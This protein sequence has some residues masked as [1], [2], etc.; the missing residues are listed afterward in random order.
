MNWLNKEIAERWREEGRRYAS[1]INKYVR[2]GTETGWPEGLEPPAEDERRSIAGEIMKMVRAA[3]QAGETTTL[4]ELI[5]PA[6]WPLTAAF[7]EQLQPVKPLTFLKDRSLLVQAFDSSGHHMVY[8]VNGKGISVCTGISHAGG[9]ADGEWTALAD[10]QSIRI[11]RGMT[12]AQEGE[13]V[14]RFLW[15]DVKRQLKAAIPNMESLADIEHPEQAL[16]EIIPFDEGRKVLLV[17][18]YG[19]YLLRNEN[20]AILLHPDL[21]QRQEYEME[22]TYIDM[23]HGDVSADG[24]WIAYGSQS[25]DHMLQE[26]KTEALFTI[27]PISSYPHYCRFS[28]NSEEVWFNA[29]HFYNGA[30]LKVPLPHLK[31][32]EQCS[33]TDEWPVMNEEMRVY[34]GAAVRDGQILGD[35]YGYLKLIASSGEEIWRYFV[36][37]TI[38]G[39]TVSHDEKLLAV[40]TYGGMLHLLRLDSGEKSEYSIG[41]ADILEL[42][43][44]VLWRNQEPLRW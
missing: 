3:N 29:C 39:M 32:N 6:S 22:D 41:T 27:Y 19:I 36:G 23:P 10:E 1:E 30:T 15:S 13:Q 25:S 42:D 44:W 11:V 18:S 2:I 26:L 28:K 38:S 24:K 37:S 40:G 31:Q 5:P 8:V 35:A 7:E 20:K 4:R 12:A 43:R 33:E 17:S 34:A 21:A 9:A 14:V 16:E